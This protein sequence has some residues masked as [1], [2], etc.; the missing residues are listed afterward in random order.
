LA[1]PAGRPSQNF[2]NASGGRDLQSLPKEQ[3]YV[4][5]QDDKRHKPV[6]FTELPVKKFL[7]WPGPRDAALPV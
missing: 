2:L 6:L 1:S 4:V 3:T 5:T 7:H